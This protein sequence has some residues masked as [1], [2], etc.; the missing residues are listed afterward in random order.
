MTAATMIRDTETRY[1]VCE[2]RRVIGSIVKL[3]GRWQYVARVADRQ[4][5]PAAHATPE[6]ALAY[7]NCKAEGS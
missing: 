7:V 6:V 4:L 5:P 1:E 2:G 3:R